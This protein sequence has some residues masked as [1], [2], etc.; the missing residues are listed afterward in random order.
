VLNI[1]STEPSALNPKILPILA[2]KEAT[3]KKLL[4]KRATK[5]HEKKLLL[6]KDSTLLRAI[7]EQAMELYG[8]K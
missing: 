2:K 1:A 3:V 5:L 7:I 4:N 6:A 8:Q